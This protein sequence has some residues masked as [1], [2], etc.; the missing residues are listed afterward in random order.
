MPHAI[1]ITQSLQNDYVKPIGKYDPLPNMLHIGY[2]EARRLMGENPEDGPMARVL[3][4][5]YSLPPDQMSIVHIRDCHDTADPFQADHLSQLGEHCLRGSE[6]AEFA[7]RIPNELA[8][9][10]VTVV[11]TVAFS[12]FIGTNLTEHLIRF[13]GQAVR[14]GLLGVWTDA[15]L[16]FLAYDLKSRFP[17]L[18]LATCSALTASTSKSNHYLALEQMER[19]LGV[20]V[21]ASVGEFTNFLAGS[22]VEI[23]LPSSPQAGYPK[24]EL[25]SEGLEVSETDLNIIRYLFRGSRKV[26]LKSLT[27]GFS[28]NLVLSSTSE[29]MHGHPEV[30]HVVKIGKQDEIGTERTAFEKIENI[31]GNS[32]PRITDF[33]DYRGRGGLKYRYAA[34]GGGIST[35]FQKLYMSGLGREKIETM[36][37]TVFEEQLGRF[38]AA[39]RRESS[40]LLE[41]YKIEPGYAARM[42]QKVEMVLGS[43]ADAAVLTLPTGQRFPNVYTFY[44]EQLEKL[45]PRA[46]GS[47]YFSYV[48]GD[49]NGAN[50]IIDEHENVWLIDFFWAHYGHALRDII[51]LECDL[52]YIWTPVEGK[53]DLE[54]ATRVTDEILKVRD[55]GKPLPP[56]EQTEIEGPQFTRAYET[57]RFLRSLYPSIIRRD[58]NL[59]QLLVGQLWYSGRVLTYPE[60]DP[61][62]K[63]W[64]LY[65]AGR[66]SN[67][68]ARRLE[69]NG[70]LRIGWLD[71]DLTRPGRMGLTLLPGRKDRGRVLGEDIAAMKR[72]GVSHVLVL[73]A[74]DEFQ[75]YGVEGLL[76]AYEEAGFVVKHFPILDH[77]VSSVPEMDH[78]V[79]WMRRVVSEDGKLLIHCLGGLG[80]SG[81]A[82]ASFLI[83][84]DSTVREAVAAVRKARSPKAIENRYQEEFLRRYAAYR[85]SLSGV[86]DEKP[87]ESFADVI[88]FAVSEEKAAVDFYTQLAAIVRDPA[89]KQL[90]ESFAR[91][92]SGH[93]R[94]LLKLKEQHPQSPDTVDLQELQAMVTAD[95]ETVPLVKIGPEM[96][97]QEALELAMFKEKSAF[98]LYLK[99]A[100]MVQDEKARAVLSSLAQDEA[101]H[102]VHF[103][104]QHEKAAVR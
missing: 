81:L 70:P 9:R 4:W 19:L 17:N 61:W 41:Y 98:K 6:G 75:E 76:E 15:K 55:L 22:E 21:F 62:Q 45:G 103:E 34:M 43:Q 52:M 71:D 10:P 3:K 38:Y 23:D 48:H 94:K 11:D 101:R 82:A 60:S 36:L 24:V 102:R 7:F 95:E 87:F 88:D 83:A 40:N 67:L 14:V 29:D 68:L 78:A 100:E 58:R 89:V 57:I 26:S 33:A 79:Q 32:A 20:R 51:K 25:Q 65:T 99:M 74:F 37:R 28:G 13:S 64:A 44:A 5:A 96:S 97:Y 30:P 72:E 1:V 49:L 27:G 54:R 77:S 47:S 18:Q 73:L 63:L 80:R 66:V 93:Y 8:D 46:V 16:F 42:K 104:L 39:A 69:A 86:G 84:G 50:I 12:D 91:E 90:L 35:T 2:E 59:Q 31:M 53:E 85:S 56:V 92:E